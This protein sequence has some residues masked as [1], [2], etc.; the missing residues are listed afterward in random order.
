MPKHFSKLPAEFEAYNPEVI[1]LTSSSVETFDEQGNYHSFD[2]KPAAF[3]TAFQE[4]LFVWFNHGVLSRGN[5]KPCRVIFGKYTY[6]TSNDA[7]NS[8]SY[9]DS[10]SNI[11]EIGNKEGYHFEWRQDG[12]LHREG[13]L[14][15]LINWSNDWHSKKSHIKKGRA[16]SSEYGQGLRT[17]FICGEMHNA[18]GPASVQNTKKNLV[19]KEYGLYGVKLPLE[20]FERIQAY[21][22]EEKV[23]LWFAFLYELD[24][25]DTEAVPALKDNVATMICLASTKWVLRSLGVNE[26]TFSDA[27]TAKSYENSE[28][29]FS[30]DEYNAQTRLNSLTNI[31]E[32]EKENPS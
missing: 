20:A 21:R 32:F 22:V 19:T 8:H 15:A 27:V 3:T 24:L 6:E 7:N 13:N 11:Y 9:E 14:P 26:D 4:D 30:R 17:W 28:Y 31:I 1:K 10:P 29:N 25:F 5:D 16:S 18:N 23:P 2:D 12:V